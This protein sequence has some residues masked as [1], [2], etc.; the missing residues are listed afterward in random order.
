MTTALVRI[1]P[2]R[3]SYQDGQIMVTPE[4]QD[5]FFISAEKATEACR[6]AV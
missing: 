6:D 2:V 5:I 3:L 1:A 4:D